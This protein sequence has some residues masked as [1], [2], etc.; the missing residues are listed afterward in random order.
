MISARPEGTV[1]A[2]ATK[3]AL[4]ALA[5]RM[6]FSQAANTTPRLC[7]STILSNTW[8]CLRIRVKQIFYP[9]LWVLRLLPNPRKSCKGKEQLPK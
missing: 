3:S 7:S 5:L 4:L 9:F 2:P 8:Q 1:I 6:V